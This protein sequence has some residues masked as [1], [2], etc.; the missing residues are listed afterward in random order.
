MVVANGTS[1]SRVN[2][3]TEFR[4]IKRDVGKSAS[5]QRATQ[6]AAAESEIYVENST[7]SRAFSSAAQTASSRDSERRDEK[8]SEESRVSESAQMG[9]RDDSL[10]FL[11]SL[12]DFAISFA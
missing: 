10:R 9:R 2:I 11:R 3:S 12:H 4:L 1:F 7:S 5:V 6:C 8:R